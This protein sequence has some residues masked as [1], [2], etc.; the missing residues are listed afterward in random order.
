MK[1]LK[2]TLVIA[3]ICCLLLAVVLFIVGC[4]FDKE[5]TDFLAKPLTEITVGG[6]CLILFIIGLITGGRW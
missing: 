4:S 2:S 5:I 6:L 3:N 1:Y